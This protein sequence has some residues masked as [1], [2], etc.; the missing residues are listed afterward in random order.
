MLTQT[1]AAPTVTPTPTVGPTPT[2]TLTPVVPEAGSLRKP[3]SIGETIAIN[4]LALTVLSAN[5]VNEVGLNKAPSGQM[6]L[7]VAILL[8]NT[9]RS[10]M[11]F[12]PLLFK[13]FDAADLTDNQIQDPWRRH[14]CRVSCRPVSAFADTCTSRS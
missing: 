2:R 11:T 7:D 4:S 8:D 14:F 12:S 10:K 6:F 3:A 5:P 9:S 1:A 13:L